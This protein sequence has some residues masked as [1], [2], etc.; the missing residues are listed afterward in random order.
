MKI[1]P[2]P[3]LKPVLFFIIPS[4]K[5]GGAERVIISLANYFS[6]KDF[7]S[8][9]ISL[10][11]DPPAYVI[12]N[13]V[14]VI[15][16]TDRQKSRFTHRAYHIAETFYKL[17]K[18]LRTEKPVCTL[19]FITSANIWAGITCSLTHV[20]YIVSERTSPERS[21][22][23]FNYLHRQLAAK[24]YKRSAAVVVSAKG[25]EDCLLRNKTF[26]KLNNIQR[27]TN[28]VTVFQPLSNQRV[29]DRRFILGV[30]RLAYV[31]GFDMLIEAYAKAGFNDIDLII[32]GDGEE[33][34]NLVC[35][36]F[37][38]GLREKVLMPGSKNNLQDYYSQAEMFVLPSRNEGYPNALVEAMSF[39]CPSIA[40]NCDFGPAEIINDRE[41]G[42]LVNNEPISG[43]TLA[44]LHLVNKPALKNEI[45][46]NARSILQTNHPDK[47][48]G[49]WETLIKKHAATSRFATQFA[50]NQPAL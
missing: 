36:V 5:G 4:L 38:L 16:L 48:L 6:K 39:G 17:I 49:E 2:A 10:N 24:L 45:G 42:I 47:I 50:N 35:Q 9:I 3:I 33:R 28:A 1:Q 41:N 44:M 30:G 20:P 43:L 21:V 26:K 18:L 40:L 31:K 32:I 27:I 25:V 8:V 23:R 15:C 13:N 34:A 11:N 37:N 22:I 29:H 46:N 14:K 12:E 7:Q 19:S